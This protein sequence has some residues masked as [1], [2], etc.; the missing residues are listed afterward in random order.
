MEDIIMDIRYIVD[1]ITY[2][3]KNDRAI[4]DFVEQRPWAP[5][6]SEGANCFIGFD[7]DSDDNDG[8]RNPI[9]FIRVKDEWVKLHKNEA[10]IKYSDNTFVV[11]PTLKTEDYERIIFNQ[12]NWCNDVCDD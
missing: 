5:M 11:K 10:V 1:R 2:D 12:D 4:F 8:A 6:E 3:G 7:F 9:W